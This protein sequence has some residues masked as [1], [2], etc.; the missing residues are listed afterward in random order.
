MKDSCPLSLSVCTLLCGAI[1]SLSG[2]QYAVG[3]SSQVARPAPTI[4]TTAFD[5]AE[6][7]KLDADRLAEAKTY[8]LSDQVDLLGI[9][10]RLRNRPM[11]EALARSI[12]KDH[13]AN[14][15]ALQALGL[16][17][18]SHRKLEEADRISQ[19]LME[20][21]P[22]RIDH[23][24]LRGEVLIYT[25]K[26]AEAVDLITPYREK[27]IAAKQ[28]TFEL[29]QIYAYALYESGHT[30]ASLQAFEE[31]T[32]NDAYTEKERDDAAAQIRNIDREALLVRGTSA[33]RKWD[34]DEADSISRQLLEEHADHEDAIAY[35]ALV[36]SEKGHAVEAAGILRELQTRNYPEDS[37][38]YADDLAFVLDVLGESKEAEKLW[39][40][41][42]ATPGL[43][44]KDRMLTEEALYE[45]RSRHRGSLDLAVHG[46][47]SGE[48]N[49]WRSE[50]RFQTPFHKRFQAGARYSYSDISLTESTTYNGRHMNPQ[51]A[52]AFI[53]RM[54]SNGYYSTAT[55][56]ATD[57]RILYG[58]E[59]RRRTSGRKPE[60]S[61]AFHGH[62]RST[63][64][65]LLESLDGYENR[66]AIEFE[67]RI[68]DRVSLSGRGHARGVKVGD[69]GDIRLGNAVGGSAELTYVIQEGNPKLTVSPV[70]EYEKFNVDSGYSKVVMAD[71]SNGFP[72]AS[73]LLTPEQNRGGVE[74]GIESR[75][76]E[77]TTG[78]GIGGLYYQFGTF[79]DAEAELRGGIRWELNEDMALI[80][81]GAYSSAGKTEENFDSSEFEGGVSFSSSF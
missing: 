10:L 65:L 34:L 59:M 20:I 19:E 58:L 81:E 53:T 60:W 39:K 32:Q 75:L 68:T 74:L 3:P 79:E 37:F 23:I 69:R 16:T 41:H 44:E 38:P 18:L 61:A 80:L 64:S 33:L 51:E 1:A 66:G 67:K 14:T 40:T 21:D 57:E 15:E 54:F 73:S 47:D 78:Y 27:S 36:L 52:S 11:T 55:V 5:P 2:C 72:S 35:S 12:L 28:P 45:S 63:D 7:G 76:T 25:G 70:W 62:R 26:A 49:A 8:P 48:G 71:G 50:V 46:Q 56:G 24:S 22:E 9:Y 77:N 30:E 29:Q 43:T 17:A 4:G 6:P 42:L 31:I 13:P